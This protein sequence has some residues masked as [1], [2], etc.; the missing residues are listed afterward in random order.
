VGK[1]GAGIY[2]G[3]QKL[4]RTVTVVN[5][6]ADLGSFELVLK[7]EGFSSLENRYEC[8]AISLAASE[9]GK[10]VAFSPTG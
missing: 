10:V 6:G 9:L 4:P 7:I 3:R 8:S 2:V 5:K 1:P